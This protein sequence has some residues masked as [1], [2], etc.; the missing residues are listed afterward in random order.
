MAESPISQAQPA[1][2]RGKD[3]HNT[4]GSSI[5]LVQP[6]PYTQ[7][8]VSPY[9]ETPVA[10]MVGYMSF[11]GTLRSIAPAAEIKLIRLEGRYLDDA[12]PRMQYQR[13]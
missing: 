10:V 6:Q 13:R 1:E 7:N 5:S 2:P 9:L 12:G 8:T 4:L 11:F 3:S